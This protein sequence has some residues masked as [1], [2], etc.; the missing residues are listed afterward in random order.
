MY[1]YPRINKDFI[2]KVFFMH[3][4]LFLTKIINFLHVYY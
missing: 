4:E 3:Q 1:F 2:Q